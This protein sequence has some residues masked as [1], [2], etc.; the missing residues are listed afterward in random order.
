MFLIYLHIQQL[1]IEAY[2][3]D[4]S[5]IAIGTP[6]AGGSVEL[7]R[8]L[9]DVANY[10]WPPPEWDIVAAHGAPRRGGVIRQG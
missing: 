1:V 6:N 10:R 9:D 2:L 3:R 7:R 8:R 4:G 5:S